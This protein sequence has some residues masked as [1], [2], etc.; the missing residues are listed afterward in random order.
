MKAMSRSHIVE[1]DRGVV[2]RPEP[3]AA[4]ARQCYSDMAITVEDAASVWRIRLTPL[5]PIAA[6]YDRELGA[7]LAEDGIGLNGI[8]GW[9][10]WRRCGRAIWLESLAN[11]WALAGWSHWLSAGRAA[12]PLIIL[13]GGRGSLKV[14]A[15]VCEPELRAFRGLIDDEFLHLDDPDTVAVA[16]ERGLVGPSSFVTPFLRACPADIVHVV[17]DTQAADGHG[18]A[19][20]TVAAAPWPPDAT[21]SCLALSQDDEGTCSWRQITEPTML[22]AFRDRD[23]PVFVHIDLSFFDMVPERRRPSYLIASLPR[24]VAQFV[25]HLAPFSG[26][27]AAVTIAYAPGLC[28]S[29][30]WAELVGELR[31][32]LEPLLA[33]T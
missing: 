33:E 10:R 8:M 13:V 1:I 19:R 21:V 15:L 30:R 2:D 11:A 9:H 27:I 31:A 25:E 4:L 32:T 7:V 20:F 24:P 16:V 18:P 5:A 3:L 6:A 22:T 26:T 12:R 29:R 17:S 14:P 28:P 23:Q